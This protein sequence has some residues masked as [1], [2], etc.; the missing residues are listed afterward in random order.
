M[1]LVLLFGPQAVGKMNAGQELEKITKEFYMK[2]QQYT[3]GRSRSS[4]RDKSGVSVMR[5]IYC[6]KAQSE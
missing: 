5:G 6:K 1:K 3:F 4:E 2:N